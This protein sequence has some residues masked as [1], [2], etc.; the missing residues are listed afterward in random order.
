[1]KKS[2]LIV[3]DMIRD[4]MPTGPL[5]VPNADKIIPAINQLIALA[6]RSGWV[7]VYANDS[8]PVNSSHF[9]NWPPHGVSGTLGAGLDDR[10]ITPFYSCDYQF[11]LKGTEPYEDGYSAFSGKFF[12]GT[13]PNGVETLSQYLRSEGVKN[14]F[15]V[16]VATEF[17]IMATALDSVKHSFATYLVEEANTGVNPEGEAEAKR[18]MERNGIRT[19]V[20]MKD[21]YLLF[22]DFIEF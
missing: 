11:I 7:I 16:G 18:I 6:D 9:E 1:M 3:V 19:N 8:H 13:G 20:T 21:I 10:V 4:F 12:E 15:I 17:C 2:A 14:V 5:P 22:S